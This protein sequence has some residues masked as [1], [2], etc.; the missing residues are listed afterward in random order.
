MR[1]NINRLLAIPVVLA[2]IFT[3]S[4]C[5]AQKH[6][7]SNISGDWNIVS[8]GGKVIDTSANEIQPYIHFNADDGRIH[9][10]T[11]CNRLMGECTIDRSKGTLKFGNLG[12]TKM[13][14]PDMDTEMAVLNALEKV[15]TYKTDDGRKLEML[16]V[17]GK[18]VLTLEFA[19]QE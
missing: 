6:V 9:G 18:N 17:D 12:S 8:V 1:F 19:P 2:G 13:M 16:D 5:R 7:A 15:V 3:L 10:N 4:S 11:G 14:C